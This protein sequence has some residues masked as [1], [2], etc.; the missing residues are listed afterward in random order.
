MRTIILIT[1]FF[2]DFAV[3]AL[4]SAGHMPDV[5]LGVISQEPQ[6]ALTS[7]VRAKIAAHWRIDN[8]LDAEQ[9]VWAAQQLARQLGTPERMFGPAEQVQV[10]VAEARERLGIVGMSAQTARNFRDKARMKDV[11]RA[12]G[13]PCAR[14][15]LVSSDDDA[16]Q[17][18]N[19]IGYPLIV[20]PPEGAAAQSTFRVDDTA[21]LRDVLEQVAPTPNRTVLME[22]FITGDEHSF[23]T[24]SL[25]GQ[26]LFHSI[27]HYLPSPLDVLRNAWMQWSVLLPREI[28]DAQYDDIRAVAFRALDTLGMTTGLSHLEWFRRRDGSLA[29]SEVGARPPGAQI[30]TLIARANDFDALGAWLRLMIFDE[31]TPP[32]RRFA[33]GCAYLRGQGGGRVRAVHGLEHVQQE[34]GYLITDVKLPQMGQPPATT[35]E[36]E[37]YV[38]VRHAETDVVRRALQQIVSTVRVELG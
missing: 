7:D 28:D 13:L 22:E 8:A 6:E 12:A 36:G 4:A 32:Q 29:I 34:F 3:R 35:Y 2:S 1:P 17:F 38:V 20:K 11:L 15:R 31:F 23:D 9:L 21:A 18:A 27:T 33:V 16:W 30:T 24:F 19:K 37:G 10:P 26:H 25:H 5:R 14:H